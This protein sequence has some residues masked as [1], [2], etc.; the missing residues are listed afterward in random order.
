[1]L[2]P[3]TGAVVRELFPCPV[4]AAA[5]S[6]ALSPDTPPATAAPPSALAAFDGEDALSALLLQPALSPTTM[7]AARIA[8]PCPT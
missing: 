4:G 3:G 2:R 8:A 6:G 5:W 7:T 1:M